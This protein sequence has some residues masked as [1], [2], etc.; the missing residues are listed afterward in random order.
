MKLSSI[1]LKTFGLLVV[2][3][4]LLS[5]ILGVGHAG[6]V[7]SG[8]IVWTDVPERQVPNSF[9]RAINLQEGRFLIL[10][11][12]LLHTVLDTAP[13]ETDL[14]RDEHLVI[15][16]LPMPDG[17]SQRFSIFESPI[18]APELAAKYPDIRTFAGQGLDDPTI[19]TRLDLTPKGFHAILFTPD[20]TI[21]IDPL[22][23]DNL[24]Y[25]ASYHREDVL[26]RN[27]D[28]FY[29][30]QMLEWADD[31][32]IALPTEAIPYLSAASSGTKLRI[33]R[34]ALAATGEY[35]QY[36]GGEVADALAAQVIAMNRVN[37]IYEQEVALRMVLIA[38]NDQIIYTDGL[39]DPYTND[40]GSK[41]L[42]ENQKNLDEVIG[43]NNYDIG[44]VFST[45]GG[46]IAMLESPCKIKFKAQGVTGLRNPVGDAFYV[47]YVAHEMGHQ[48][49]ANHTYN[50]DA[51]SCASG[52][53]ASAAYEPGSGSTIMSY[54]GICAEQDLQKHSDAYFHPISFDEI[55]AYTTLGDGST[56]GEAS[57]TGNTPPEITS[58]SGGYSI[59][60]NTPFTMS[61]TATDADGDALTY[62]WDEMDLGKAGPPP[63]LDG[64]VVPPYF[65]SFTPSTDPYRTFPRLSDIV[66]N[67]TTIGEILPLVGRTLV[68]RFTARDN[69][70]GGGGVNFNTYSINVIETSGPFRVTDP[71]VYE[72]WIAGSREAV[73]WDVAK[74]D[75]API[76]CTDVSIE[77][78]TDGGYTYPIQLI[79]R[80][81]N[82]GSEEITVPKIPSVTTARVRVA[83][84]NNIFFDISNTD[85]SI[86]NEPDLIIDK[87]HVP[88]VNPGTSITYTLTIQNIGPRETD[89]IVTVTDALPA[90]LTAETISGEGWDCELSTL[91]C[92]RSDSLLGYSSYPG[93]VLVASISVPEQVVNTASVSGGGDAFLDNNSDSDLSGEW[94]DTF[95]PLVLR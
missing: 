18:M 16:T 84:V 83:C 35:T 40:D 55:V 79:E 77:L 94:I 47:D 28:V 49:G 50:G 72:T 9:Q 42:A 37:G 20:G 36:H 93:I 78:S 86:W 11:L 30:P 10:N 21:Y 56:C 71:N 32:S 23:K 52:R 31:L 81:A 74:T 8:T 70:V 88:G 53:S 95:I 65:R 2:L 54:A 3:V 12:K 13:Q 43:T 38:N 82:D 67:T 15:L 24:V 59:P 87:T 75:L 91:T 19:T 7:N 58:G 64:Y 76:N 92:N 34:L 69:L 29:E 17:S 1:A 44:H 22:I 66:N 14:D 61:G 46:G 39:T 68:F 5:S 63:P 60:V 73:T 62:A 27:G 26:P 90:T 6:A 85:L 25:Y 41:M 89:G 45:G 4:L 57:E 33:Y 51:G 48:W 80:T